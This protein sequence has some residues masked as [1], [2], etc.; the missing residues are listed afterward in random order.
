MNQKTK[1]EVLGPYIFEEDAHGYE[2]VY[3]EDALKA[4]DDFARQSGVAF[5]NWIAE[6]EWQMLYGTQVWESVKYKDQYPTQA[7]FELFKFEQSKSP[8]N[9]D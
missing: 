4:M 7:L 3:S 2:V 9:E 5:A 8:A 1:E 6:N